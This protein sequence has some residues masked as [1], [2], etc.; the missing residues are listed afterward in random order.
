M[1]KSMKF[2]CKAVCAAAFLTLSI[3]QADAQE[4]IAADTVSMDELVGKK[5]T[6]V[7]LE[8]CRVMDI[9]ED[10]WKDSCNP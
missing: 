7:P 3:R 8:Q 9:S 10:G 1:N 6:Q 2:L 4:T 5:P